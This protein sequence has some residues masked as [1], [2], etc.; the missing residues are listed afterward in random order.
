MTAPVA[1]PMMYFIMVFGATP[2]NTQSAAIIHIGMRME[3][4]VSFTFS[5]SSGSWPKNTDCPT[6]MKDA[7]VS[8][9]VTTQTTVTRA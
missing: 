3:S 1:G 6:L 9:L 8:T 2:V 4:G 5:S 7:S